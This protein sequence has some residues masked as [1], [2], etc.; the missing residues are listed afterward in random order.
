MIQ[1]LLKLYYVYFCTEIED[2][3]KANAKALRIFYKG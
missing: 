3:F 2:T 1:D